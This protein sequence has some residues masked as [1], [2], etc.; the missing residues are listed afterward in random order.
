MKKQY[1]I[2]TAL[3]TL[4]FCS[5][6]LQAQEWKLVWSDEFNQEGRLD[7]TAWNY[8]RGFARN[9]EAQWYQPDNA[10]CTGGNLV[11]EAR[12]E[13]DRKN[14]LYQKGSKDWRR[15][16]EFIEYTSSSVTTA[17]KKEFLYG[18]F[19]VRAK[20]PTGGGSWPA[21]WFLGRGLPWPSCGEIDLMEYYRINGIPHILANACWGGE[22][23]GQSVWDDA[24]IPFVHFT[25]D[26][27]TWA[28]RFH[29]WRMDW[30]ERSIKLYLDDELINEI[31][32]DKTINGAPGQNIN[33]FHKPQYI[34]LN[35]AL[36]GTNGGP[37]DDKAIPMKYYID[38][39]RVYQKAEQQPAPQ[40]V[41]NIADEGAWC[42][43]A[44]PRALHY[45]NEDGSINK[46]YVGYIDIHGAIKA[47]QYDFNAKKQEEVLI[48]SYF[49]PDDHNNPTFLV[50]PDERIMVFYSR[51][52]DEPCFYYRVS[53]LPGDITTLGEEKRI[54]TK[55]NTTY[56]SP[57][58]LS[59]DPEHIYLCWR[60]IGWH[61]TIAQLSLPDANDNVK[62][63]W[64]PFQMVKST[65]A[66]P[67][68]KYAS[69]G[70]DKIYVTYTT[71]HPDNESPNFLYLNV[72][73]IKTKQLEDIKGNVLSTIADGPLGVNKKPEY[74]EKYPWAV[75]DNSTERDWVWQ[76]ALNEQEHPVIA[77]T[78]INEDKS[79]HDYYYVRWDGSKWMKTFIA[80][81]DGHFHQTL[82]LEK[83]Y[84]GG[85]AIDPAKTNTLYCSVPVDGRYGRRYEIIKYVIDD[86]GQV[87]SVWPVTR[88]S[89]KNNA[90]PFV[91]PG[92]EESPLRLAWM[93]GDYYDWIV[94]EVHPLGYNTA[95]RSTFEGFP[96][97]N[98]PMVYD[99]KLFKFN[100]KKE[101]AMEV[102][103]TPDKETYQGEL[104]Q[105][106]SLSYWL[107]GETLKPEVRYKDKV[108]Q[109]TN[110]LA[111]SDGWA[112]ERRGTAGHW[113][114]PKRYDSFRLKLV[115][116]EGVLTT[117]INGLIDQKINLL[118]K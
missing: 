27:P 97:E 112:K 6:M 93:H 33:P 83:C 87:A 94:S 14:P 105:L 104:L 2:I 90:R 8:E 1:K 65:G 66:R 61:P 60:G 55:Q 18:R 115:Y 52:T 31:L 32:L 22:R 15:E 100:P 34:L 113:Y 40:Q 88:H 30:D 107:N 73:N 50:L 26:D 39:V 16:R 29:V 12:K 42:W 91:L 17:A 71:G 21:I 109:S 57:F 117:Y 82:H 76:I 25:K 63:E 4:F 47:M 110:R 24:K 5:G 45:K 85:M 43:F 108:Y 44:D 37:I 9:H 62:V 101:F 74:I 116:K 78:R 114:T 72:V 77:M 20:I 38:Y 102:T 41:Y 69:N 48:R 46:S 54:E 68:A 49:Q 80:N 59:D 36:G 56:P 75:V 28:D 96:E 99:A 106:G 11:I 70:K 67:Y 23:R 19:E 13:V 118:E 64:G 103:L 7:S 98:I 79:S 89:V 53:R 84:S 95:I 51:H 92:S 58:I 81:A 3:C 10:Y 86:N 35:L 111:T